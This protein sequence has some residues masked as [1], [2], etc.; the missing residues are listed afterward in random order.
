MKNS[1][2][3]MITQAKVWD[4]SLYPIK[5][6]FYGGPVFA[7][8]DMS[9]IAWNDADIISRGNIA[10]VILSFSACHPERSRGISYYTRW[11]RCILYFYYTKKV[12]DFS[13]HPTKRLFCE[14]PI[15]IEM[16]QSLS[17]KSIFCHPERSRGISDYA[18]WVGKN[19]IVVLIYSM[20][21]IWDFSERSNDITMV[22]LIKQKVS[23][24]MPW[25]FLFKLYFL[26]F[27]LNY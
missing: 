3:D 5:K 27:L 9:S 17:L 7:Q 12:W 1:S 15:L 2:I 13:L 11:V 6:L 22:I 14:D 25:H 10:F 20:D 4:V 21:N 18:C 26:F 8:H 24:H 19:C 16:T 23:K